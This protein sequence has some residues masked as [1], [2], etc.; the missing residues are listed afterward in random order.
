MGY[1]AMYSSALLCVDFS[2]NCDF[3]AWSGAVRYWHTLKKSIPSVHQHAVKTILSFLITHFVQ[4]SPLLYV[5]HKNMILE[6][7]GCLKHP[8][9]TN[10]LC[11]DKL[12]M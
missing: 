1:F 5:R 9:I 7:S 3:Q 11:N 10:F 8:P 6:Y 4:I 2:T 12:V